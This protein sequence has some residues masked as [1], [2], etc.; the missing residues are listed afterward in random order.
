VRVFRFVVLVGAMV[1]ATTSI[2]SA[3]GSWMHTPDEMV[4][5]GEMVEFVGYVGA[6]NADEGPWY[7]Y[8]DTGGAIIALGPVTIEAT[9]LGGYLS[10]RVYLK[11]TVPATLE[12]GTYWVSVQNGGEF[13]AQQRV[14][15]GDLIGAIVEVGAIG[16]TQLF[17][18][19]LDEPLVEALPSDAVLVGPDWEITAGEVR[20]GIYPRCEWGCLLDPTI[21]QRE[22]VTIVDARPS[23]QTPAAV[24][25][26]AAP[27]TTTTTA[28]SIAPL[29]AAEAVGSDP[30][31]AEVT[32]TAN[33]QNPLGGVVPM[34]A[35]IVLAV[36]V[37]FIAAA[38]FRRAEA[39]PVPEPRVQE[40]DVFESAGT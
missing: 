10:Y 23:W 26:T 20:S 39:A 32:T 24:P 9:G 4:E 16:S 33:P 30:E 14:Y 31:T 5:S 12:P 22:G 37:S 38:R 18:W 35:G 27:S 3:G 21:L 17:D 11:F 8:L 6:E 29:P 28:L 25:T 15:L 19:P 13:T 34:T 7:A 1:V 40:V 36:T 2:A